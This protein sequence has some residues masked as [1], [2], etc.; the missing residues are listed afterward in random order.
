VVVR[1]WK[2]K[3]KSHPDGFGKKRNR[4]P[5][6]EVVQIPSLMRQVGWQVGSLEQW[7]EGVVCREGVK[8]GVGWRLLFFF[9]ARCGKWAAIQQLA[10]GCTAARN[11]A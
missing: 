2:R 7:K 6:Y 4:K 9:L 3:E 5:N 11:F 8:L 1:R 10:A